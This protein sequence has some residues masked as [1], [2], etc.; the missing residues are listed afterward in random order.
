MNQ[1]VFINGE[2]AETFTL[3]AFT[4]NLDLNGA[5]TFIPKTDKHKISFNRIGGKIMTAAKP[6]FRET[7]HAF[8]A[9]LVDSWPVDT[10][11][12][13]DG[14]KIQANQYDWTVTNSVVNPRTGVSYIGGLWWGLPIGSEQL[15]YGGD[16]ILRRHA[17]RL[18]INLANE[19]FR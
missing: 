10:G 3:E 12:S 2:P 9:E 7:A 11:R 18:L 15:P 17:A 5:K 8:K 14:W 13:R 19:G 4:A 6:I 1:T 16:P